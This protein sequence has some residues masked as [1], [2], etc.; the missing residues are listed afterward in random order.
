M[1]ASSEWLS[2]ATQHAKYL[3][4]VVSERKTAMG[5]LSNDLKYEIALVDFAIRNNSR[6]Q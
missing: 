1:V 5:D 2:M 3:Q 4:K 6:Q